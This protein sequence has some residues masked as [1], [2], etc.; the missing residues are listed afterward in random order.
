MFHA[1]NLVWLVLLWNRSPCRSR[2]KW[3]RLQFPVRQDR[4]NTFRMLRTD[5]HHGLD[6]KFWTWWNFSHFAIDDW[7]FVLACKQRGLIDSLFAVRISLIENYLK[8]L[9]FIVSG[10]LRIVYLWL[11]VE[12]FF[13]PVEQFFPP[14]VHHLI[15]WEFEIYWYWCDLFCICLSH[16]IDPFSGILNFSCTPFLI[17]RLMKLE[18]EIRFAHLHLGL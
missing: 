10:D 14:Q 18:H 8:W 12:L 6:G 5:R 11:S 7:W 16:R 4:S 17:T 2:R 1:S 15:D 3:G 9:K 13:F